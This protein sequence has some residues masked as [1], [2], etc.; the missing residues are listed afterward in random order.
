MR[1]YSTG[2]NLL[3]HVD[4]EGK[5]SMVDVGNKR[6]TE[7][8]AVAQSVVHVGSMVAKQIAMNSLKKG[9][10]LTTAQIAGITNAKKT[11]EIIP[12]CHNIPLSSVKVT[13]HLDIKDNSVYI[14]ARVRTEGG[15]GVEMEALVAAS[16]AA[17]TVY[18]MCK[19]LSHD[20]TIREIRLMEKKGGKR[21][22]VRDNTDI[23]SEAP[24]IELND[25]KIDL[26]SEQEMKEPFYPV[27]I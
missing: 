18:D 4:S 15:T 10:V 20:I 13:T 14:T 12:M 9:D 2:V 22:Y 23:V 17:L 1:Y 19:A 16:A 6:I 5:V 27:H 3:T 7:R 24:A 8:I 21:D 11:S 25:L 26:K